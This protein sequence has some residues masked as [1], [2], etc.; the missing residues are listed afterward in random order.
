MKALSIKQPWASLIVSGH[1]TV[2]MRTWKT[3]YR[4]LLAIHASKKPDMLYGTILP[5]GNDIK[6]HNNP[7]GAIIATCTLADIIIYN[8]RQKYNDDILKHCCPETW[9]Q[10]GMC[11]WVLIDV[12]KLETP[13]PCKGQLGLWNWDEPQNKA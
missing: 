6:H 3:S 7:L 4:G 11:G 9:Y 12:K 2:E 10:K 13:I 8:S 5:S 1:K